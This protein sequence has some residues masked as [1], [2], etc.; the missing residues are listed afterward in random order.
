MKKGLMIFAALAFL[1][2]VS[3]SKDRTCS[4]TTTTSFGGATSTVTADTTLANM[5]KGD[6]KTTC[7]SFESSGDIF[8]TTWDTQCELK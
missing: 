2:V 3:C 7:E 6:A 4:C 5:S 1:A 8:G